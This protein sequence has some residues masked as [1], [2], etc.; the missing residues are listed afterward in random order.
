MGFEYVN[1]L[2]TTT[3]KF[4]DNVNDAISKVFSQLGINIRETD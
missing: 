4:T 2:R 1:Y 3:I